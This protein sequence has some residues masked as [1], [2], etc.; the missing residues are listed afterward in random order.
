M[1]KIENDYYF[2]ESNEDC[3]G[4]GK[5]CCYDIDGPGTATGR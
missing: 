4:G 5:Y 2:K 1:E 3:L